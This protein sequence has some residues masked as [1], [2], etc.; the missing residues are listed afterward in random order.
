MKHLK[1]LLVLLMI[2]ALALPLLCACGDSSDTSVAEST[3]STGAVADGDTSDDVSEST[4]VAPDIIDLNGREINVICWAWGQNS[5][6]IKGYT[7]EIMYSEED[8]SSRVDKAKK[9]VVDYIETT[10]NCTVNGV[11][12]DNDYVGVIEKM[13]TTGTYDYDIAFT[14]ANQARSMLA[15][16]LL[17]DLN[18]VPSLN[19]EN[20]WWD[21][22]SVADL[23]I[24]GRLFYVCGDINTYD[25]L[26]TWCVLFNKN[27]KTTLGISDDF[28]QKAQDGQWTMDYFMEVCKDVTQEYDGNSGI[29]EF[30]LW[31]CGTETFNIYAHLV[32]GG[33]RVAEKDDT[34][35]P[36]LTVT[37]SP[38]TTYNALDKIITFYNSPD[39][40]VA[41]G[42]KFDGKGYTN[43][44]ESTINKAFTEGRELFYVCGLI[45]VAGFRDMKDPFGILPMPMLYEGQDR[46]YH[47]VSPDN[48]SYLV[49]PYGVPG[50][51]ELG[52]VVE[53]LAMKS[54]E[55]V[56]PEFYDM[57]LKGRDS[58][59]EESWAM[60]DIIFATRCFDL[61][62]SYNWGSIMGCYYSMDNSDIAS[63]FD[64][65]LSAAQS[66]IEDTRMD[67]EDYEI[68]LN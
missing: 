1:S 7:G 22:N 36:Y 30:D 66:A 33:I 49:L 38:E 55:L 29:D 25:N 48:S 18:T 17:T 50:I 45:N 15:K 51:E 68:V 4:D 53:A 13:V 28:Y 41:N 32:G 56:T 26:G 63:S 5:N 10:Y 44:W 14:S 6:S 21:Q 67:L 31:A 64:K 24:G 65:I 62:V 9:E 23:S 11:F 60:L 37:K 2:C 42:G 8:N 35:F 47:T 58:H 40:M 52:V 54:Q 39:V 57:Q 34:D 43:V 19:F 3:A 27:L 46:Y 16:N 61:G 12:C 20:S 59:D